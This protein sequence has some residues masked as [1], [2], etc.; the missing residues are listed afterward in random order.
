MAGSS[1]VEATGTLETTT[2]GMEQV[3]Y[4]ITIISLSRQTDV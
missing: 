1:T 4:T 3:V 2:T